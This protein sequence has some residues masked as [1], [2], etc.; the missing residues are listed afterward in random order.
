MWWTQVV[1]VGETHGVKTRPIMQQ[2]PQLG[3]VGDVGG[4]AG[5]ARATT[6]AASSSSMGTSEPVP[7][8]KAEELYTDYESKKRTAHLKHKGGAAVNAVGGKMLP[9]D[10]PPLPPGIAEDFFEEPERKKSEWRGSVSPHSP[11]GC[12]RRPSERSQA[13]SLQAEIECWHLESPRAL[14]VCVGYTRRRTGVA[15]QPNQT[16]ISACCDCL[17]PRRVLTDRRARVH[18]SLTAEA[19]AA[20]APVPAAKGLGGWFRKKLKG[21]PGGPAPP[22]SG[23][24]AKEESGASTRIPLVY[25]AVSSLSSLSSLRSQKREPLAREPTSKTDVT[26]LSWPHNASSAPWPSTPS[27]TALL[28]G[29]QCMCGDSSVFEPPWGDTF[30]ASPCDST[31]FISRGMSHFATG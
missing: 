23:P 4:G 30:V 5:A 10:L 7:Q 20:P 15:N 28:S 14:T 24:S 16:H 6:A 17:I 31:L 27:L 19:A 1:T 8:M 22:P 25:D 18:A 12:S 2:G 3:G 11:F 9:E 29:W 26:I 21:A 13:S